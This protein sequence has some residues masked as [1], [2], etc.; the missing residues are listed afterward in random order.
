MTDP[1]SHTMRLQKALDITAEMVKD[2]QNN[3]WDRLRELESERRF[4][5]E[6][7]FV[8]KV[9]VD[10]AESMIEL[11]ARILDLND[12]LVFLGRETRGE[13]SQGM[14]KLSRGRRAKVAYAGVGKV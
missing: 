4:N 1:K 13:F 3:S 7:A 11:I 9:P 6:E 8:G 2:A 10:E 14:D 12:E 5:I